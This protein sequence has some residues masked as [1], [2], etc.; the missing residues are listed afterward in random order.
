MT[1]VLIADSIKPSLVMSS[2][3]FKDKIPGSVVLV[4]SNGADAL[5]IAAEA[6]PDICL[7]DF[8]LPDVDGP[9]LILELRK[10]FSGPILMTAYPDEN[11]KKSVLDDLFAFADASAWI[12]K[13]VR[14]E[15]LSTQID[16]YLVERRRTGRR[17]KLELPT[18]V[19]AKAGASA[20]R[21]S[22][23]PARILNLSMGGACL[24]IENAISMK[25]KQELTIAIQFLSQ[26]ERAK[27]SKSSAK[28]KSPKAG[29]PKAPKS[30]EIKKS[31]PETKFKATVAWATRDGQVG[32]QFAK[33][34]E[35][36]QRELENFL[37][38]EARLATETLD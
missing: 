22:K 31:A 1:K 19:L 15:E 33:L 21:A 16:K 29:V 2:E 18:E 4:A 17:F 6:K 34:T 11:V 9:A 30:A 27:L 23:V 5:R 37:K 32:L 25:K 3:V 13:P 24:Q 36:Q 14:F 20:K 38:T 7:V 10:I 26:K 28:P 8:D 12:K 35:A